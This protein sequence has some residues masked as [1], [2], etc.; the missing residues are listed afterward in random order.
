M[1]ACLPKYIVCGTYTP[2][3]TPGPQSCVLQAT[4]E[5]HARLVVGGTFFRSLLFGA[6][7]NSIQINC[8]QIGYNYT[9]TGTLA[10]PHVGDVE[11]VTLRMTITKG[12]KLEYYDTTQRRQY[13]SVEG[14][15]L[16]FVN[17]WVWIS[18]AISNFRSLINGVSMLVAMPSTDGIQPWNS[19][20]NDQNHIN[21]F[22]STHFAHGS[23]PAPSAAIRTGPTYTILQ[24]ASTEDGNGNS[25][26]TNIIKY[27]NSKNWIAFSPKKDCYDPNNISAGTCP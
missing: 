9:G 17:M 6:G 23:P 16:V 3:F 12:E 24:I 26:N 25:V 11:T 1:S 7:E 15:P 21:T 8:Q 2:D 5:R 14:P 13:Q 19:G 22:G 10:S 27:W 18:N 4:A 20:V